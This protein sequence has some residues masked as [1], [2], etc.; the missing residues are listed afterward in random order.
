MAKISKISSRIKRGRTKKRNESSDYNLY[1]E[2]RKERQ[3]LTADS[4][5]TLPK[6][7]NSEEK[8]KPT[9]EKQ[10]V[11]QTSSNE[12]EK[13]RMKKI[14]R[15]KKINGKDDSYYGDDHSNASL[16]AMYEVEVTDE[17]RGGKKK[18]R[19]KEGKKK[20]TMKT[21]H[22]KVNFE[23]E[24]EGKESI[25]EKNKKNNE[26]LKSNKNRD[27]TELDKQRKGT[28]S[29][30]KKSF[31]R[32]IHED[33]VSVTSSNS[34]G[35]DF[36]APWR[37]KTSKQSNTKRK[38]EEREKVKRIKKEGEHLKEKITSSSPVDNSADEKTSSIIP[39]KKVDIAS[40]KV[41]QMI[42]SKACNSKS[43]ETIKI[44]KKNQLNVP[45][46]IIIPRKERGLES[47]GGN[48][49][50]EVSTL[51]DPH[52]KPMSTTVVSSLYPKTKSKQQQSKEDNTTDK[53]Q[54]DRDRMVL[55]PIHSKKKDLTRCESNNEF[56]SDEKR[57]PVQTHTSEYNTSSIVV[58]ACGDGNA[59]N[60]IPAQFNS[61]DISL[62]KK[63][64]NRLEKILTQMNIGVEETK[65][66]VTSSLN[67]VK[68]NKIDWNGSFMLNEENKYDFYDQDKDG[69]IVMQPKVPMFPESFP[70]GARLWPLEWW[71][72]VEP[73]KELI[74]EI[75][76]ELDQK[77][78][79]SFSRA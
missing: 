43:K 77:K 1:E 17:E 31:R 39:K 18:K 41:H 68:P 32:I 69:N 54:D 47:S 49:G 66:D 78:C 55:D 53:T 22:V 72:I 40:S 58:G 20:F 73:P 30:S 12:E 61:Q 6:K 2:G 16:V 59:T 23:F 63:F 24:E 19:K 4:S 27:D 48:A 28:V 10:D 11:S 36:G 37:Q 13:E 35:G 45:K 65:V 5:V 44:P 50:N 15:K 60:S 70:E 29:S 79:L 75:K 46:K 42:N 26:K 62:L 56:R 25:I 67:Q 21:V 71:G 38:D 9:K 8:W 14:P 7:Q 3:P 33:E 64:D 76:A 52:M 34:G 74:D 51:I 57:L